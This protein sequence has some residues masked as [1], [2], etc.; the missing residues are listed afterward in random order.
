MASSY[1]E[2]LRDPRWQRKR[3]EIMKR[4]NFTCQKCG[5]DDKPLNVHHC[6]YSLADDGQK[7]MPW[8]YESSSL[9]TLCEDCYFEET[10]YARDQKKYL[11]DALSRK[12]L[13]RE[14]FNE[15]ASGIDACPLQNFDEFTISAIAWT[16]SNPELLSEIS[17]RFYDSIQ[18]SI[19]LK[20]WA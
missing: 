20:K 10:E 2:L 18:Q 8:D 12:G 11:I 6:Y 9:V 16:L 19:R 3:L 5:H 17:N 14:G 13:M 7:R 15:I 1:S 4:D